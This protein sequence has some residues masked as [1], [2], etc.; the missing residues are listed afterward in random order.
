MDKEL[1]KY[2][3]LDIK[4]IILDMYYR[5]LFFDTVKE[6]KKIFL[7][8]YSYKNEKFMQNIVRQELKTSFKL[9]MVNLFYLITRQCTINGP[10]LNFGSFC[11]S[12][13]EKPT[14]KP[15]KR[16]IKIN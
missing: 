11:R 13:Q 2:F 9:N 5:S 14:R 1:D 8:A 3:P 16:K 7:H 10:K 15:R 12:L 6:L 4:N